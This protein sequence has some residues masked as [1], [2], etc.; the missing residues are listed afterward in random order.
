M[1]DIIS[2][3]S[4]KI[5]HKF[6]DSSMTYL[7]L[8]TKSDALANFLFGVQSKN[9]IIVFGGKEHGMLICFIAALKV[10]RPYIPVDNS[11][12]TDRVQEILTNSNADVVIDVSND[13]PILELCN[14]S[15][16]FRFVSQ[17]KY[18]GITSNMV[19]TYSYPYV[20]NLAY[21]IYTSGTS[22]SPKGVGVSTENLTSFI[23]WIKGVVKIGSSNHVVLNQASFSFDLSILDTYLALSTGSTLLSISKIDTLNLKK[24]ITYL[25]ENKVSI[26]VST[27]SFVELCLNS[28]IFK[29]E[30]LSSMDTFLFCGEVLRIDTVKEIKRKFPTARIINLYGP[31]ETTVAVTH[32]EIK[33]IHLETNNAIPLG[34][35]K[36]GTTIEILDNNGLILP[37]GE[38]GEIR[39]S[40]DSVSYGYFNDYERTKNYFVISHGDEKVIRSYRTGDLGF[41]LDG[42]L[43]FIGRKDNQVKVNGYR[44]ELEDVEQNLMRLDSI[45][46]AFV[47]PKIRNGKAIQLVAILKMKE[48][49]VDNYNNQLAAEIKKD[50]KSILPSYMVPHQYI[51]VNDITMNNNGKIDKKYYVD[52]YNI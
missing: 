40:G 9:P 3:S 12:P 16:H 31:T 23:D 5:C 36:P 10:N 18:N 28:R 19:T 38:V 25:I 24:T 32:Q 48:Y 4:S 1:K 44:I 43:N 15:N 7:E 52:K 29:E 45:V 49:Q 6:M 42:V 50:L 2:N 21:I 22:G 37:E 13:F 46:K 11:L 39:I 34:V 8:K 30:Y 26:W 17:N 33:D 20:N 51:F 14:Y 35:P 47:I 27:P 41:I